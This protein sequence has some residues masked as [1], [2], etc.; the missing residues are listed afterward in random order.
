MSVDLNRLHTARG[1][2]DNAIDSGDLV[3]ASGLI[4][5][6]TGALMV[7]AAGSHD[8]DGTLP[9]RQDAIFAIAS[10]TKLVTLLTS[11]RR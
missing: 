5:D 2:L 6:K 7:H 4:G 8:A 11:M 1:V 9:A 10:L 3:F